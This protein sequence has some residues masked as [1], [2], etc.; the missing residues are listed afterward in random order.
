[1]IGNDG[2]TP[3]LAGAAVREPALGWRLERRDL[4]P[5]GNDFLLLG[6]FLQPGQAGGEK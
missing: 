2:S 4:L 1:L 3:M 5:L 6:S